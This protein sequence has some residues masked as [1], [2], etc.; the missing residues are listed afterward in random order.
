LTRL[1]TILLVCLF[2]L[3]LFWAATPGICEAAD[4]IQ[5]QE[6]QIRTLLQNSTRL[7]QIN[8]ILQLN[9][10]DSQKALATAL[11]ELK[12][13]KEELAALKAELAAL[14]KALEEMTLYSKKQEDL[15]A[16]INQSFEIYSK[17]TKARI[18]SLE[19]KNTLLEI[20]AG[21]AVIYAAVK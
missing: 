2:S 19:R 10:T 12:A 15:I 11:S 6:E 18:K 21:A 16:K 8:E 3:C 5:V 17:E 20:V 14:R 7:S 13:S 9:S 1:K 4:T